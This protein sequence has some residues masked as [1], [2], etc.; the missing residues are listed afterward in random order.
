M[1]NEPLQLWGVVSIKCR[2]L[3]CIIVTN[4][5][6]FDLL[7]SLQSYQLESGSHYVQVTIQMLNEPDLQVLVARNVVLWSVEA[8]YQA[9]I[10]KEFK[11]SF[12]MLSQFEFSAL[13]DTFSL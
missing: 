5:V 13:T 7:F 3:L 8:Y 2:S 11:F 6:K 4:T 1:S 12:V 10:V 9:V